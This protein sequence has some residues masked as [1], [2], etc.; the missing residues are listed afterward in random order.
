MEAH[1]H[2]R[3]KIKR[4]QLQ[5]FISQF[6]F[7]R[8][9]EFTSVRY[10]LAIVRNKDFFLAIASLY[11][12]ILTS[13]NRN[14]SHNCKLFSRNSDFFFLAILDFFRTV[15]YK[16]TILRGKE[17][18]FSYNCDF[19][20]CMQLQVYISQFWQ[21]K[22]ELQN[23]NSQLREKVTITYFFYILFSGRNG[24]PYY[25]VLSV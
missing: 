14:F 16:L 17:W 6:F 22:L 2:H 25:L 10:K 12:A 9:C 3:I 4:W 13:R 24:F 19:I 20:S 23:V 15:R 1:F 18:L 21:R 7:P 5:L 11:L 8:N